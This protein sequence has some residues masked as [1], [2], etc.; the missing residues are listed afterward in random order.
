MA[1]RLPNGARAWVPLAL[2]MCAALTT[3]CDAPESVA[4]AAPSDA[5]IEPHARPLQS[6]LDRYCAAMCERSATCSASL[7]E[8][9]PAQKAPANAPPL[10]S[11]SS[12]TEPL[13]ACE[14]ECKQDAPRNSE[15]VAL[16]ERAEQCLSATDCAGLL[17]CLDGIGK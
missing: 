2:L 14:R 4:V 12:A 6:Q 8:T 9:V 15:E 5:V 7:A 13:V 16:L 17:G 1:D 11:S 3:A 10:P